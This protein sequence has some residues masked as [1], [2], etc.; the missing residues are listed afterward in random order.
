MSAPT[1]G[2]QGTRVRWLA[3]QLRKLP[4]I[5]GDLQVT[6]VWSKRGLTSSGKVSSLIDDASTLK[7]DR[8]G[9]PIARDIMPRR[10]ILERTRPLPNVRGRSTARVLAGVTAG[11]EDFYR[12]V[13][14]DLVPF[15]PRPPRLPKEKEPEPSASPEPQLRSVS[16][17][18]P[19]VSERDLRLQCMGARTAPVKA[20]SGYC[21]P[22]G[23]AADAI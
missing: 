18:S 4:N 3:H 23:I 10:F 1:E 13:V 8:A 14:E 15:V 19:T 22:G 11:L 17:Y 7:L 16:P 21:D 2:R 6:V 20:G 9:L 5:P 12:R